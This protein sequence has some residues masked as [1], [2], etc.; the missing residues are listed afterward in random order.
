M[1]GK[2]LRRDFQCFAHAVLPRVLGAG[3]D[4]GRPEQNWALEEA[5]RNPLVLRCWSRVARQLDAQACE[6]VVLRAVSLRLDGG[7]AQPF[8]DLDQA[9]EG[10][11]LETG[12]YACRSL[13][14]G[15]VAPRRRA[16][17]DPTALP[18]ARQDAIE[19]ALSSGRGSAILS[20]Q[21]SSGTISIAPQGHSATH[22]PQPLQ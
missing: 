12:G 21:P 9:T 1:P 3:R 20:S 11:A 15:S 7:R 2:A 8:D 5:W 17:N 13:P 18:K 6:K 22:T 16:A 4:L 10:W 14:R 19:L